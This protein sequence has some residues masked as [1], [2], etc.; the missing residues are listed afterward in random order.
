MSFPKFASLLEKS[1]LYCSQVAELSDRFEGSLPKIV[2]NMLENSNKKLEMSKTDLVS[3]EPGL[4]SSGRYDCYVSC[5]CIQEDE[6]NALWRIYTSGEGGIA[7][8]TTYKRL[9]SAVHLKSL[10]GCVNYI[11]FATY[12][13]L[14]PIYNTLA[15]VM[16]KR[17]EYEYEKEVRIAFALPLLFKGG[18]R[19]GLQVVET[20]GKKYPVG[21]YM[22][23]ELDALISEVIVSP[24]AA[25]WYFDSVTWLVQQ[26]GLQ[27]PVRWSRM[28]EEPRH[29]VKSLNG[30]Y[31]EHLQNVFDRAK[32]E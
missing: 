27:I 9:V 6:S 15:P 3:T 4:Y 18:D 14:L 23:V 32:V 21:L 25:P 31:A 16:L 24:N 19:E 28:R 29:H 17:R 26:S 8:K 1:A 10:V 30:T 22:D 11:D 13:N 12:N 20:P 5:W 2:A 7:L